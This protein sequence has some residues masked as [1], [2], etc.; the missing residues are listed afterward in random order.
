MSDELNFGFFL[1]GITPLYM[2][3]KRNLSNSEDR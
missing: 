2:Q 3:L 1:R